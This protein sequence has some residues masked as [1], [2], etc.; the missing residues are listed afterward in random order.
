[1]F[2]KFNCFFVGLQKEITALRSENDRLSS[3]RKETLEV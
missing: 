2:T 1:M 3:E